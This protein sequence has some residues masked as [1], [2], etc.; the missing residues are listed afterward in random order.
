MKIAET[1]RGV[2]AVVD[3]ITVL[4]SD[5]PDEEIKRGPGGNTC[6]GV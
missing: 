6:K 2:R 4:P 5:R 1:V 3:K